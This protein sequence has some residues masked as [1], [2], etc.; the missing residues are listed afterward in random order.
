M[1]EKG[2]VYDLIGQKEIDSTD[3]LALAVSASTGAFRNL[4][5]FR[6]DSFEYSAVKR[7]TI[8]KIWEDESDIN[9][10]R[11][12]TIEVQ[13]WANLKA[14]NNKEE[15]RLPYKTPIEIRAT[16]NWTYVYDNLPKYN[17]EGREIFYDVTEI[18]VAGYE[19]TSQR[20]ND[21]NDS[22]IQF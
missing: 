7:L 19:S 17:N 22:E 6:F 2:I 12:D 10:L 11:P 4:Q 15:V 3:S 18:P 14:T 5:Q 1:T 9:G 8:D 13:V 21:E 16:D 20:L